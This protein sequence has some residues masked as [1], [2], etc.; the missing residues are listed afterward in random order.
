LTDFEKIALIAAGDRALFKQLYEE[1]HKRAFNSALSILQHADEAEEIVQDVF[2][3]V[4]RSASNFKGD[5]SIS[6]WL[7]RIT[8]NK[9]LDQLRY[10][11]RKK[12]SAFLIS[13]FTGSDS[14]PI[15]PPDFNHPGVVLEN[16]ENAAILFKVIDRLPEQQKAA[17]V[18]SQIEEL[19]QKEISEILGVSHK[20]VESLIQRAKVNLRKQLENSYPNRRKK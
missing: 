10:R 1:Y 3:E 5:S 4:H 6:T 19:P 15:Q 11:K 14:A 16:K 9:S 20:A 13:L 17:F 12:R 8:V 2:L 7:Y 18:L